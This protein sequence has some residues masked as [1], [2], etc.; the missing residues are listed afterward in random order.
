MFAETPA[1]VSESI[2]ESLKTTEWQRSEDCAPG[3]KVIVNTGA[4]NH[5]EAIV[6]AKKADR[7]IVL[8]TILHQ[9]QE[10]EFSIKDVAAA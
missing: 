4:F 6:K 1:R 9:Q 8:M 7:I 5:M 3:T 10:L 2:I